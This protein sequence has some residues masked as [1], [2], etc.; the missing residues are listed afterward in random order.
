MGGGRGNFTAVDTEQQTLASSGKAGKTGNG[1]VTFCEEAGKE[2]MERDDSSV[3]ICREKH[4]EAPGGPRAL[5][6][7][8]TR[9][10]LSCKMPRK[11][12]AAVPLRQ[13]RG[14][15]ASKRTRARNQNKHKTPTKKG[16]AGVIVAAKSVLIRLKYYVGS[17]RVSPAGT[18]W[19][20][21]L[22]RTNT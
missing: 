10:R 7:P 1:A 19:V 14:K 17:T 6:H 13:T 15:S 12:F 18:W 20:R 4:L 2:R 3:L 8:A 16:S 21:G 11:W 5:Q 9:L 22:I